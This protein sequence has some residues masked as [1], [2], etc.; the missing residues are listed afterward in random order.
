[1]TN[2]EESFSIASYDAL[3]KAAQS[4]VANNLFPSGFGPIG[5]DV[6]DGEFLTHNLL[7]HPGNSLF[8]YYPD[9]DVTVDSHTD[10]RVNY[11]REALTSG[12][13]HFSSPRAF[14]DPYDCTLSVDLEKATAA[15]IRKCAS[16]IGMGSLEGKDAIEL[17]EDFATKRCSRSRCQIAGVSEERNPA[18]LSVKLFRM[19]MEQSATSAGRKDIAAED[20]IAGALSVVDSTLAIRDKTRV[21]CLSTTCDNPAMW[22]Y[23]ANGHKGFCVEYDISE[24]HIAGATDYDKDRQTLY[25]NTRPVIYNLERPD[26]TEYVISDLFST[27]NEKMMDELYLRSLHSK[28]LNWALECEWRTVLPQ[29]SVLF[30]EHDNVNFFPIRNVYAGVLMEDEKLRT[31][32]SLCRLKGFPLYKVE[33]DN[34]RYTLRV[35][36]VV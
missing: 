6:L 28:G 27:I 7:T 21:F 11:S 5:K 19:T 32:S 36:Q 17:A 1:M 35:R 15:C 34:R 20:V 10:K 33:T 16:I 29:G 24:S 31:L 8:H 30:D 2:T 9:V 26:C 14:N 22:A 3:L 4:F 25:V 23:Y 13:V 12:K 18:A